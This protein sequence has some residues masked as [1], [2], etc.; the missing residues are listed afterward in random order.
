[1]TCSNTPTSRA[2]LRRLILGSILFFFCLA[3]A[4]PAKAE[5]CGVDY[6]EF[7]GEQFGTT[8]AVP[9]ITGSE[10]YLSIEC[11]GTTHNFPNDDFTGCPDEQ[12]CCSTEPVVAG[13][14]GPACGNRY[15]ADDVFFDTYCYGA[16]PVGPFGRGCPD[17]EINIS[18]YVCLSEGQ[19]CCGRPE[20][21]LEEIKKEADTLGEFSYCDQVPAGDQRDACNACVGGDPGNKVYTAVGCISTSGSALAGDLI[22]LFLGVS[23]G[24]ALLSILA[25][26]FILSTSRGDTNKVKQ[27][28]DL[29]TAAVSGLFFIIFSVI[30]LN[31]I[32]VEIL[33]IPGL[34]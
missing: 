2:L 18:D 11:P 13:P 4:P 32:G 22:R 6:Y 20:K 19:I 24:I 26:S 15:F 25:A 33:K 17:G 21:T 31:F 30:I 16:A 5:V 9:E 34:G 12:I 10:P 7:G 14:S 29:M 27:A 28:K 1:M 8:C 23:G 3:T